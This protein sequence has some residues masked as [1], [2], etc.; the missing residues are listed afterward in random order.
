M[1]AAKGGNHLFG[2]AVKE[3]KEIYPEIAGRID[4]SNDK[5]KRNSPLAVAV[6][7]L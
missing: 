1:I 3:L 7:G 5:N 4:V 6:S 2:E